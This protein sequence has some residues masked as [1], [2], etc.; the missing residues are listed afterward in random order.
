MVQWEKLVRRQRLRAL[1]R[2]LELEELA[3][4]LVEQARAGSAR[5]PA[6]MLLR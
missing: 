5:E 1:G 6:P 3:A 4:R 2:L